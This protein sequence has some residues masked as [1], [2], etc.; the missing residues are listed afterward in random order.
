M[1][2]ETAQQ[3]IGYL[4]QDVTEYLHITLDDFVAKLNTRPRILN[5]EEW[6]AKSS[7][8][9]FYKTNKTQFWDEVNFHMIPD[10]WLDHFQLDFIKGLRVLD[11]GCGIGSTA[12]YQA[13]NNYV[14]GY[15]INE[16]CLDFCKFR[17]AKFKYDNLVFTNVKP[18]LA[19]FQVVMAIDVLE[20]IPNL[21][22]LIA[23]WG[24]QAFPG[25]VIYHADV[26]ENHPDHH[27]MH[28]DFSKEVNG[29]FKEAGFEN[30]GIRVAI[31]K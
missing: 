19:G 1:D 23:E 13:V 21:H 15:D 31:K 11:Y 27:P 6:V 29:W 30:A 18:S 26:F 24:Q 17:K 7:I 5:A 16:M 12:I 25:T 10:Y 2:A 4:V 14:V 20:H 8:E 22:E 28:Y 9:E 3:W